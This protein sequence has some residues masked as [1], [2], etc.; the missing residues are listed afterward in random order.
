MST[1]EKRLIDL[2]QAKYR[3]DPNG[4]RQY[5][6]GA[7]ELLPEQSPRRRSRSS[8]G[9]TERELFYHRAGLEETLEKLGGGVVTVEE[10]VKGLQHCAALI[11]DDNLPEEVGYE[12]IKSLVR[13]AIGKSPSSYRSKTTVPLDGGG[14]GPPYERVSAIRGVYLDLD[15]ETR[16]VSITINPG[17]VRERRKLMDLVGVG[18]DSETDV[19]SRHDDY[20]A[21][22]EPH[23]AT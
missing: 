16:L 21:E 4:F 14:K 2:L 17:K 6:P 5:L 7:A 12:A 1:R 23:G 8:F 22:Q 13:V 20:L 19:A 3:E 15:R 9:L 11:R 18:K 10:A